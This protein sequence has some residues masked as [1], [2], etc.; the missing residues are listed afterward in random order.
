MNENFS[1]NRQERYWAII[2]Y[3]L[4]LLYGQEL[5]LLFSILWGIT[6]IQDSFYKLDVVVSILRRHKVLSGVLEFH[7]DHEL[8][9]GLMI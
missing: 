7:H 1:T 4:S 2:C 9:F 5:W 6:Q 8:Y 3:C